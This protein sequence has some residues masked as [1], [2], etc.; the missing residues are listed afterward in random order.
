MAALVPYEWLRHGAGRPMG[1]DEAWAMGGYVSYG[2]KAPFK[3]AVSGSL[4]R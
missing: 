1:R 3:A 2:R 4:R